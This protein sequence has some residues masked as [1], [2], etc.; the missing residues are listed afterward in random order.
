MR[1]ICIVYCCIRNYPKARQLKTTNT[2]GEESMFGSGLSRGCNQAVGGLWSHLKAL[3]KG[4]Q[5]HGYWLASVPPHVGL[6]T[7]P[8]VPWH[9]ASHRASNPEELEREKTCPR[10][11][12]GSFYNL[13]LEVTFHYFCHILFIRI[14]SVKS[15]HST[16][17][18][19]DY[20]IPG[21]GD[22][23]RLNKLV[24]SSFLLSY[25]L[26]CWFQTCIT[27]S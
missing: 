15:S 26:S 19:E 17:N 12:P 8:P 2:V 27:L 11:K 5:T 20:T 14:K 18:E 10:Q 22:R 25:C 4:I 7:E 1:I 6:S 24:S 13:I 21:V 9:P 3:P 23:W 16:I